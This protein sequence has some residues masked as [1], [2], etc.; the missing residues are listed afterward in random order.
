MRSAYSYPA[1][2]I[3]CEILADARDFV[4]IWQS[5]ATLRHSLGEQDVLTDPLHFLAATDAARRSCSVA[6]WQGDELIG[7]VFATAHYALGIPSGYAIAGDFTGRGSLLCH[8]EHQSLVVESAVRCMLEHGIHSLHLRISPAAEEQPGLRNLPAKQ[9]RESVP[10][11]R[12]ALPGSFDQFLASLG[13]NTRRNIRRYTSRAAEAGIVFADTISSTEYASA[14]RRINRRNGF[15]AGSRRFARDQR[16]VELHRGEHFA[17]R[18]RNGEIVAALRGVSR[19]GRF[20]VLS[21]TNDASLAEFSLSL[22]LRGLTI[23]KLIATGHTEI[24]FMGGS[25]PSL[26]RLC[27]PVSYRSIFVDRPDS[28]FSFAKV[29]ASR[30]VDL[31]ARRGKPV[32]LAL[33]LLCGSYL[34]DGRLSHRTAFPFSFNATRALGVSWS[35]V[36][37]TSHSSGIARL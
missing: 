37:S 8:P 13:S 2:S 29:F 27:P 15:S 21:Q 10:G 18:N 22:V 33:K 30:I 16:L 26:S 6:C 19:N 12:L 1:P 36:N 34:A 25:S 24:Q 32:P 11:D 35:W 17:L 7:V 20:H 28:L 23:E 14:S 31:L 4:R 5:L 9:L 3:R